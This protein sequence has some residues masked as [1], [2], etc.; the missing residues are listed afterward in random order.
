MEMHEPYSLPA[1]KVATP[2]DVVGGPA[3]NAA[4]AE[5]PVIAL[6][7]VDYSFG[8][9]VSCKQVLAGICLNIWPGEIVIST[10]P[11]GSGKTT[12]LTLL[13][14][15]RSPQSG[16]VKVLGRELSGLDLHAQEAVR[17]DIGFIFQ[18]HHLF[19]SLTALQTLR[20]A[21]Q[22]HPHSREELA[23]R[24]ERLLAQLDLL[25]HAHHKPAQMSVGQ[26]QRVAIGRALIN[27]PRLILADEPTAALDKDTGR[28]VVNLLKQRATEE[29][30]TIIIVT[31]DPRI[32]DVADRIIHLV[33]GRIVED[34]GR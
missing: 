34:A 19:A 31:H 30:C 11:S 23:A 26:C 16:S 13:G 20:L 27:H 3:S 22:L 32:L 21:M 10:G 33:D 17:R 25:N 29:G 7:G 28:L 24:P 12:L 15:L 9:G 5:A 2:V 14:A 1:S 8:E 6:K 18:A 4:H